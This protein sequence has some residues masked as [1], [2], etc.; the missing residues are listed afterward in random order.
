MI[1]GDY[2]KCK[3]MDLAMNLAMNL[4]IYLAMKKEESDFRRLLEMQKHD[5]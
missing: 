5:I 3:S 1:L 2:W 4:A